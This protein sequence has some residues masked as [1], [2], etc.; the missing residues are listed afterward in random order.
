MHPPPEHCE[1]EA[2]HTNGHA[3]SQADH[4]RPP[5]APSA[6]SAGFGGFATAYMVAG[7]GQSEAAGQLLTA[8]YWGAIMVGRIAAIPLSLWLPADRYLG[9]SMGGCVVGALIML[10]GQASVGALWFG[11]IVYGLCMACVFPT[12]VQL[13][14]L[15]FPVSGTDATAFVVGSAAGEWLLPFIVASLFGNV[16]GEADIPQSSEGVTAGPTILLWVVTVGCA[17][18]MLVYWALVRKGRALHAAL[19]PSGSAASPH[20]PV[21]VAG[22]VK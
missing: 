15:Y 3:R 5:P 9:L 1:A 22:E 17:V 12:A 8:A 11:S 19:H 7:L 14:E 2:A 20:T 10:A 18:N 6:A 4:T 21:A 16:P 13:A